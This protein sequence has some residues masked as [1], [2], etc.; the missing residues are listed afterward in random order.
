MEPADWEQEDRRAVGAWLN[1]EQLPETD[2]RGQGVHDASFLALFN[3]GHERV[4][5][6]LPAPG[7]GSTWA[8]EVDTHQENGEAA[9]DAPAPNGAYGLE[10]RSVA[11]LRQVPAD[12]R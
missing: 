10:A 6:A 3:A 11:V 8:I 4:E 7:D 12:S 1:G 9:H 2:D 5:F